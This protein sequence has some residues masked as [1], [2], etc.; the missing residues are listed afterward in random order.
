[1]GLFDRIAKRFR[2]A[3][4]RRQ[5]IKLQEAGGDPSVFYGGGGSDDDADTPPP[6]P[7]PRRMGGGFMGGKR[8]G[9]SAE[10]LLVP[11]AVVGAGLALAARR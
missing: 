9:L 3:Q 4:K 11:L 1:M 8:G 5:A 2:K 10:D 7:P 6:P